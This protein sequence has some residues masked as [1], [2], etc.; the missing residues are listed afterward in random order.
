M[1]LLLE[2][3][4]LFMNEG[5]NREVA[6][7]IIFDDDKVLIIRRSDT[8]PWKPGWWDLPGGNV[9]PGE[10][11]I[12]AAVREAKEE[13]NLTVKNLVKVESRP[14][15]RVYRY[16]YATKDWQGNI[17]F[18]KN[19]ESGFIEHDEYEW[20]K[21][22]NIKNLKNSLLPINTIRKAYRGMK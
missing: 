7:C 1:K 19:P 17:Q 3:W 20:V 10:S 14:M 11:A 4:R 15:G 6:S 8:D 18:K 16:Y 22:E 12:E 13:T 9:D 5:R 2:N 21:I